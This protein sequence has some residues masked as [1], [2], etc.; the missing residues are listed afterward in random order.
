MIFDKFFLFFTNILS[1]FIATND[2][3]GRSACKRFQKSRNYI[4]P[5][6]ETPRRTLR[7]R[8]AGTLHGST[9]NTPK[10]KQRTKS[11]TIK[12]G[13]T[14]SRYDCTRKHQQDLPQ[15]RS[16]ACTQGYRPRNRKGRAG[17]DHGGL[18]IGQIDPA[19][20]PRDPGR[21]RHGRIFPERAPDQTP[22]RDAGR[23]CPQQHDR[24]YFPVVQPDK[25]QERGRKRRPSPLLPGRFTPQ[26]QCRSPRI[27]RPAGTPRL[28]QPHAQRDVGRPE[29]A[30]GHRPGIDQ[31]APDHSRRRTY[32]RP[33]QQN[34]AGGNGPAAA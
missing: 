27:P 13:I 28:G 19:E 16:A 5:A 25:L 33:G 2:K 17:F 1:I 6:Q 9:G 22:E 14:P 30:R 23:R 15:R 24:L 31:Q 4:T 8:P 21:L 34:L 32:G 10:Q 20:H 26:A 12:N 7:F 11:T 18:G 29:A 3:N